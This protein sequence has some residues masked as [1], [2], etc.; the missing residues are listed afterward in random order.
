MKA[1]GND[2]LFSSCGEDGVRYNYDGT[3]LI[4]CEGTSKEI[5]IKNGTQI[6][7]D[8]AFKGNQYVETI[9]IPSSV[10]EIGENAFSDC[11]NLKAFE[12]ENT[13]EIKKGYFSYDGVL[14][15]VDS[16][17]MRVVRYPPAKEQ[18]VYKF[19]GD[20]CDGAFVDC[21]NL[22]FVQHKKIKWEQDDLDGWDFDY[23]SPEIII[24][25]DQNNDDGFDNFDFPEFRPIIGPVPDNMSMEFSSDDLFCNAIRPLELFNVRPYR[26]FSSEYN[27]NPNV[28]GIDIDLCKVEKTIS[29]KM[30]PSIDEHILKYIPTSFSNDDK[31]DKNETIKSMLQNILLYFVTKENVGKL[32]QDNKTIPDNRV[33]RSNITKEKLN[34]V[35]EDISSKK[36]V[37]YALGKYEKECDVS[38]YASIDKARS[39][40]IWVDEIKK[41]SENFNCNAKELIVQVLLHELT[42]ALMDIYKESTS[43]N[44][45]KELYALYREESLANGASLCLLKELYQDNISSIEGIKRFISEQPLEYKLGLHYDK[46]ETLENEIPLWMSQKSNNSMTNEDIVKWFKEQASLL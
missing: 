38:D 18:K 13:E 23:E 42:H 33:Y 8:E 44:T 7:C 5:R 2:E 25:Q 46:K 11:P 27:D 32:T 36:K 3:M 19:V 10:T 16:L 17:N 20:S 37:Y 4:S 28:S 21:Y 41:V 15:K 22:V 39:I 34:D 29:Q 24:G 30:W 1:T 26:L 31:F 14:F 35:T 12:T 6:I 9:Y 45:I 43:Q 40:Y